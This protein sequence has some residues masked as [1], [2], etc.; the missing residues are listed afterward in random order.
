MVFFFVMA[1][2]RR[3]HTSFWDDSFIE[4]L[5]VE[6]RY[7][8]LFLLTNPM[9]TECG[10]YQITVKKMSY[11]TGYTQEA[12]SAVLKRFIESGKVKYDFE[13]EEIS[14]C[15]RVKY[16]EN[17]G[18]PVIDCL[19]SEYKSVKNKSLFVTAMELAPRSI[20]E[21]DWD[22]PVTRRGTTRQRHV[23]GA[24]TLRGEEQEQEQ[25]E[26]QEEEMHA[27]QRGN[28]ASLS[29]D[30]F[31]SEIIRQFPTCDKV[32]AQK[33]SELMAR[34]YSSSRVTSLEKLVK[35]WVE[36]KKRG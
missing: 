7:F 35:K 36:N 9:S 24:S 25:E 31:L 2:F 11:Y 6:D 14:I 33:E 21:I 13:T 5:S 4:K 16:I 20:R 23:N 10:V 1:K 15:N 28:V 34:K 19:R 18:M 8:Y 30:D 17:F 29:Y 27:M 12:I 26:E 3:V 32:W 22:K